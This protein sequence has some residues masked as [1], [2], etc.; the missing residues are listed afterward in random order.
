MTTGLWL[1]YIIYILTR[2]TFVAIFVRYTENVD[3]I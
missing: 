3:F 1:S 2:I